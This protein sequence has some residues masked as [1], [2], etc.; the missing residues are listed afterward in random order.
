MTDVLYRWPEA[1]RFGKIIPKS[2]FYER[3][4]VTPTVRA[5]FVAEVEGITWAYKLAETTINLP[6]S[7]EVPEIQVLVITAKGPNVDDSVL[8]TIDK[9]IKQ[10][11]IFEIATAGGTRMTSTLKTGTPG[12]RY[13]SSGWS[14]EDDRRPLPPSITLSSLYAALLEPL[15]PI[16]LRGSEGLSDLADR[17]ARVSRLEREV[18]RLERKLRAEPQLN[19]K[20]ELRRTLRAQQ[21]TLAD[22]TNATTAST[23]TTAN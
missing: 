17:L 18:A 11:V 6:S 7:S 1:A 3:A 10:P 9:A 19:R 14:Q 16:R 22:L 5:R 21:G 13:Y 20:V 15:L 2:K 4:V 8:T 12:G 23:M